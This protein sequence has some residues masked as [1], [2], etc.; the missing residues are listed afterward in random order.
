MRHAAAYKYRLLLAYCS[1]IGVAAFA[2]VIPRIIG[3]AVDKVISSGDLR[4]LVMLALAALA[5]SVGRGI[6]AYGQQYLGESL[7]QRV[8]YD[9]RNLYFD[10]MQSLSFAFHDSQKSGDLMSR[11]T[12]DVEGIRMFIQGGAIRG[13]FMILLIFGVSVIL[14]LTSWKLAILSLVF[15]PLIILRT[16]T[17]M[18]A[19]RRNWLAEREEMGKLNTLLQENLS[20]QRVVKAFAAEEHEKE[21]FVH[22]ASLVAHY[23]FTAEKLQAITTSLNNFFFLGGTGVILWFGGKEVIDGQLTE[24]QL[25]SFLLY[26]GLL[27]MPVRMFA[28][29]VNSFARALST[30]ERIFFLLDAE[31][32]VQ[33]SALA[34]TMPKA[35]GSVAFK[36]V[37][38]RYE[39]SDNNAITNIDIE[40]PSSQIVAILG[41]PGSGKST[42]VHLIPR[43]YDVS[44]G[45]ITID[46]QD[47]RDV[48]LKSLRQNVG[49][50]QQDIFIFT[51]TIRAN[52]AYGAI[53]ASDAE[54]KRVAEL[55]Q[56]HDFIM[57]LPEGYDTYVG[58]RGSTLSGG[59]RQ[60]LAIARTLLMDPP[61]L[62]LD[63]STSSVD[64]ETEH[65]IQKALENVMEGRTT[66]VIAHRLS[67][68]QKADKLLVL[69][70][71]Y[72]VQQGT[73]AELLGVPGPY[74]EIYELQL[75]PQETNGV[76]SNRNLDNA[77]TLHS[78]SSPQTSLQNG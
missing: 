54:V 28:F 65:L 68:V 78:D 14:I 22:G 9:I 74:R 7:G 3:E 67:S 36:N 61:V 40:A 46:G 27:S 12:A 72:I 59:Q 64:T 44:S 52:I 23:G 45:S 57:G 49:I 55:A 70:K 38:F 4:P 34:T 56:M 33:E 42:L 77:S 37:S 29:I 53:H 15:M 6:C 5:V 16:S 66:F 43:F 32:P 69:D 63:D 30:G 19:M 21:K 18:M 47:I 10:K 71:G 50:V 58:E 48:T 73:H 20:G 8:A 41:A 39:E 31:S 25:V 11:A 75:R 62:I 24:G 51:S 35:N 1:S 17:I 26:M 76:V 2:L 60:R 13:A